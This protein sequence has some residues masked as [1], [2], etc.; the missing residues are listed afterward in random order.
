LV[1]AE[2]LHVELALLQELK[3]GCVVGY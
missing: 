3:T 1:L 2:V